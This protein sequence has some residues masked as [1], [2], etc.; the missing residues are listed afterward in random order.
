MVLKTSVVG[1]QFGRSLARARKMSFQ[2]ESHIHALLSRVPWS[3]PRAVSLLLAALIAAELAHATLALRGGRALG[4]AITRTVPLRGPQGVDVQRIVTAHLFGIASDHDAGD[5]ENAQLSEANLVL[6]GTIATNDPKRGFAIIKDSGPSKVYSVGD[7]IG[8][9]ALHSVYLDHVIL[10]RDGTFETLKLPRSLLGARALQQ[11][12]VA[13]SSAP[14]YLDSLGRVVDKPPGNLEKIMRI[15]ELID[16][17][18]G[19]MRGFRVYPLASG[20]PMHTLGLYPGDVVTAINGTPLDDR[21]RSKEI[22][23]SIQSSGAASVTIERQNQKLDLVLNI[24][25]AT[26]T[27]SE[28][29]MAPPSDSL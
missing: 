11:G 19:K 12:T 6:D 21:R 29:A 17:Q 24:A 8:G 14:V 4:P 28:S 1:G 22:L 3:T 20:K 27:L 25:E 23:N 5:P 10:D 2:I 18:T 7:R 16:D 13:R 15:N 9:A 26:K